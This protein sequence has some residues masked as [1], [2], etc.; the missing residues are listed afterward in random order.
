MRHFE[1]EH[2]NVSRNFWSW[3]PEGLLAD[4]IEHCY[5]NSGILIFEGT[6]FDLEIGTINHG[7]KISGKKIK[8]STDLG[9]RL[10]QA[11]CEAQSRYTLT[12][13]SLK[14]CIYNIQ[15]AY[16]R[17]GIKGRLLNFM[18]FAGHT[19]RY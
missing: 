13:V 2:F 8:V 14:D 16:M 15:Q 11:I 12:P 19:I 1:T 9:G 17:M 4:F 10:S 5:V 18:W 3:M 6:R 7:Y